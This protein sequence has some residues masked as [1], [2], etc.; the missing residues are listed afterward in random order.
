MKEGKTKN[1]AKKRTNNTRRPSN[2]KKSTHSNGNKVKDVE[3][4]PV[5]EN[6]LD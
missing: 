4:T 1:T 6:F 2:A 3:F 5:E